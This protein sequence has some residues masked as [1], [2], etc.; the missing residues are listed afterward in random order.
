M[1]EKT[2][3]EDMKKKM[4]GEINQNPPE[5]ITGETPAKRGRGRPA[6]SVNK[7]AAAP[8]LA[9]PDEDLKATVYEMAALPLDIAGWI[10]G[11]E[12]FG[13]PPLFEERIKRLGTNFVKDFGIAEYNRYIN[14]IMFIGCYGG[15]AIS[16]TMAYMDW[17][18]KNAAEAAKKLKE[19]PAKTPEPKKEPEIIPGIADNEKKS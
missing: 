19:T 1:K 7:P 12:G 6:G 3:P 8:Q 4:A 2:K 15:L 11:Y 13:I 16:Q 5:T 17:K 9:Y 10:T 14:G 18:K